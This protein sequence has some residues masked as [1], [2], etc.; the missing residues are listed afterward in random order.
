MIFDK[1]F[2]AVGRTSIV[3]HRHYPAILIGIG[4]RCAIQIFNAVDVLLYAVGTDLFPFAAG[5]P[6]EL[7]KWLF[8]RSYFSANQGEGS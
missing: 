7:S 1:I 8:R 2:T 4:F 6:A 3:Y 5:V